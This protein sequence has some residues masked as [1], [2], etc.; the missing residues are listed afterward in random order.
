MHNND[1]VQFAKMMFGLSEIFK[2]GI[3]EVGIE[4]YFNALAEFDIDEVARGI[5]DVVKTRVYNDMPKPAE[6]IK[7][8]TGGDNVRALSAWDKVLS[9][10]RRGCKKHHDPDIEHT[11]RLCGGWPQLGMTLEEDLHWVKKEF[12]E[13]FI[14]SG[15][16]AFRPAI[17]PAKIMRELTE[18]GADAL[19]GKVLV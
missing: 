19:Q 10:A 14:D 11:V 2:G 6:I 3:S 13:A 5:S 12:I 17:E 4:L 9:S 8:I 16:M 15:H 1:R 7:A 18:R